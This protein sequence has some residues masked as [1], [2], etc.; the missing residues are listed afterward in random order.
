MALVFFIKQALNVSN[1]FSRGSGSD[2]RAYLALISILEGVLKPN[3]PNR[4]GE[5]YGEPFDDF[6]AAEGIDSR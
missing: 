2:K 1:T 5:E 4:D 3:V 6:E